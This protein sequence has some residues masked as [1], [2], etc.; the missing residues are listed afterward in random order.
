MEL[1]RSNRYRPEKDV[2]VALY[3]MLNDQNFDIYTTVV[4]YL[5][6]LSQWGLAF[7]YLDFNRPLALGYYRVI[8]INP[9]HLTDPISCR[10]VHEKVSPAKLGL[11]DKHY[12]GLEFFSPLDSREV[13]MLING[14]I[15]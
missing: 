9:H 14:R 7:S 2:L 1:R 10:I 4:G 15:S 8:L 3:L 11:P 12:C 5:T 13:P 6:D